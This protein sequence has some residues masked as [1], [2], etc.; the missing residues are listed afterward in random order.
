[1]AGTKRPRAQRPK[2]VIEDA[3]KQLRGWDRKTYVDMLAHDLVE[4]CVVDGASLSMRAARAAAEAEA[5]ERSFNRDVVIHVLEWVLGEV[6]ELPYV[7]E[8][9]TLEGQDDEAPGGQ[10]CDTG[11]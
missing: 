6:D 3:V 9:V 10:G 4:H 2:P 11:N 7:I 8:Q 5:S 1:M